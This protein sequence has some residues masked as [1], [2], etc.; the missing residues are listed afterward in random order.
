MSSKSH[1]GVLVG[2]K[3]QLINMDRTRVQLWSLAFTCQLISPLP[4]HLYSRESWRGLHL[5]PRKSGQHI[6]YFLGFRH[7]IGSNS[8]FPFFVARCTSHAEPHRHFIH[9]VQLSKFRSSL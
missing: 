6:N 3:A 5:W 2:I 4:L 1:V 7:S 9:L 8:F